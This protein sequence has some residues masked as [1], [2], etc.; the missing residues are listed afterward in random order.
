MTR[1]TVQSRKENM[2]RKGLIAEQV[3]ISATKENKVIEDL[4]DRF[5]GEKNGPVINDQPSGHRPE[6]TLT[7]ARP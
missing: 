5:G 6:S 7:V 3:G 2:P 1:K 4:P